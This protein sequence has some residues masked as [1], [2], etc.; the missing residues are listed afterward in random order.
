TSAPIPYIGTL[1]IA[2]FILVV[3]LQLAVSRRRDEE[4]LEAERT[5]RTLAPPGPGAEDGSPR[6]ACRR[7][8][9]RFQQHPHGDCRPRRHA[10]VE[11]HRG[12]ENRSRA[13]SS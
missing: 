9:A 12:F 2:A 4:L 11:R 6:A 3:A 10:A 1:G 8:R 5:Q 7:R 13:D